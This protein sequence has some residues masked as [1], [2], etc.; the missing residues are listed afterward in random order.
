[1]RAEPT[2]TECPGGCISL[3]PHQGALLP[4]QLSTQPAL[5]SR[6]RSQQRVP[7]AEGS[8]GYTLL[9]CCL[10]TLST[11][12]R[13]SPQAV[14]FSSS[15]TKPSAAAG[16][17]AER[18]QG[19]QL[20]AEGIGGCQDSLNKSLE[21]GFAEPQ[22]SHQP[23]AQRTKDNA[24]RAARGRSCLLGPRRETGSSRGGGGEWKFPPWRL[25]FKTFQRRHRG[26]ESFHQS[27][28]AELRSEVISCLAWPRGRNAVPAVLRYRET[29]G[30]QNTLS[31]SAH[32]LAVPAPTPSCAPPYTTRAATHLGTTAPLVAGRLSQQICCAGDTGWFV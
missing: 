24:E 30:K 5:T 17:D 25:Y 10:G 9:T 6:G 32:F 3:L 27:M 13:V 20:C 8:L 11:C 16:A 28:R 18:A 22:V 4:I 14:S 23:N 21:E 1:V 26:V 31:S 7:F 19:P 15:V 29:S 12:A 2:C